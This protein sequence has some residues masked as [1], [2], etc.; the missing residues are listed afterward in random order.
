MH[1][2]GERRAEN[3][4]DREGQQ[5]APHLVKGEKVGAY[6]GNNQCLLWFSLF[7]ILLLLMIYLDILMQY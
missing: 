7:A 2:D 6:V 5:A 3:V 1:A 4:L